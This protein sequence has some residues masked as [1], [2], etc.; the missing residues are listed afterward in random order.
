MRIKLSELRQVIRKVL[1]EALPSQRPTISSDLDPGEKELMKKY[2][3][4]GNPQAEKIGQDSPARVKM[5]QVA[6][7]LQAKGLTVDAAAKKKVTNDLLPFL[8]K[9]DPTDMFAADPEE[10]ASEFAAKVLGTQGN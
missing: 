4:W 6:K 1:K 8:E 3:H 5:K 10:I 2:P 9:M 7:I